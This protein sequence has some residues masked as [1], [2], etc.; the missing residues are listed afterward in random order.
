MDKALEALIVTSRWRIGRKV[1]RTIYVM[2]TT[3]PT[4]HDILIGC[5]DS[6]M[7]AAAAVNA[8]NGILEQMGVIK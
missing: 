7:I 1:G 2:T 3:E 4:D 8:H 6:E 5:M